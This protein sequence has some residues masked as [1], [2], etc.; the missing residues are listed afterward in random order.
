MWN[1]LTIK[2]NGYHN[3]KASFVFAASLAYK[4]CNCVRSFFETSKIHPNFLHNR[5]VKYINEIIITLMDMKWYSN[6]AI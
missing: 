6:N 3:I 4:N 2:M 1:I 5:I